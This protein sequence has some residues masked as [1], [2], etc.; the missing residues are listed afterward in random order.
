M[1]LDSCPSD[2][3]LL[4]MKQEREAR[5]PSPIARRNGIELGPSSPLLPDPAPRRP[6]RDTVRGEVTEHEIQVGF[7]ANVSDEGEQRRRPALAM[8][9][10][11]PNGGKRTKA[12]SAKL[13]AEGVRRGVPDVWCPAPRG[14]YVGWVAEFK[15]PGE[16]TTP[17]QADWLAALAREGWN[18]QLH[19]VST[20]AFRALCDHLDEPRPDILPVSPTSARS[21]A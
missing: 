5:G 8:T 11:V 21:T 12:V 2:A 1:S 10:A 20:E 19:T 17:E 13:K 4:R 18:A 3:E 14:R 7:F 15:R 16:A 6:R 9:F